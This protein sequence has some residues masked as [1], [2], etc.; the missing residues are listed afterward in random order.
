MATD[1]QAYRCCRP[2]GFLGLRWSFRRVDQ[3]PS[4]NLSVQT[5][6][7]VQV[8]AQRRVRFSSA[9]FVTRSRARTKIVSFLDDDL[10]IFTFLRVQWPKARPSWASPTEMRTN[11][12]FSCSYNDSIAPYVKVI[13]ILYRDITWIDGETGPRCKGKMVASAKMRLRYGIVWKFSYSHGERNTDDIT[14]RIV[15]NLD[16][17]S[18]FHFRVD[19]YPPCRSSGLF[20]RPTSASIMYARA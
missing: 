8:F 12:T 19:E 2:F 4:I 18:R 20:F 5:D 17:K 15:S 3:I 9:K 10:R 14:N 1:N 13:T 16:R 11:C 6:F 7:S